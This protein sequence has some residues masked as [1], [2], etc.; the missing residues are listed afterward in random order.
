MPQLLS[1]GT[2]VVAPTFLFATEQAR[3]QG[4]ALEC[5]P[6]EVSIIDVEVTSQ[7]LVQGGQFWITGGQLG[8]LAQFSIIDKNNVL[9][10]HVL[11]GIPAGHPIELVR[12]VKDYRVP[13]VTPWREEILMPTV[14]PVAP[15]LFLRSQYEAAAGGGRATWASSF[16]GT[17]EGRDAERRRQRGQARRYRRRQDGGSGAEAE[18][19]RMA[20]A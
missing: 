13:P 15:G 11:H 6:G 14:A 2:P 3:L 18:G 9:G 4:Y 12:Y 8:D 7:M 5:E 16:A 17:S 20:H 10:L 1:D 19:E